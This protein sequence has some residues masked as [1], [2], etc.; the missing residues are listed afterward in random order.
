MKMETE[1]IEFYQPVP[2][3]VEIVT[4]ARKPIID[5]NETRGYRTN[6]SETIRAKIVGETRKTLVLEDIVRHV[7]TNE[8]KYDQIVKSPRGAIRKSSI[9]LLYKVPE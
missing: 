3:N 5:G 9:I 2:T 4:K 1:Y 7:A 6:I 8:L